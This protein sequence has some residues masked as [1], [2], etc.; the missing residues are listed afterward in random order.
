M[1]HASPRVVARIAGVFYALTFVAGILALASTPAKFVANLV[2]TLSYAAVTVLFYRLF[3]PVDRGL[4]LLAAIV[5][6]VGLAAGLLATFKVVDIPVS[7]LVFFGGYCLLIG[8]LIVRSTFLPRVVGVLMA[9]GGLGW[10]TFLSPSLARQ[11]SPYNLAP[12]MIGEGVLT[13]W[14]LTAGVNE[15]RW[16]EQAA[17]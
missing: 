10:L 16:R 7:N 14:L 8:T 11:L 17:T 13:V 9:L 15:Q 1:P 6:A 3:A 5:S 4:S 2:A 12:G